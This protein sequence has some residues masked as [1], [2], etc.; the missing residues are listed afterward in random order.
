[1]TGM[2]RV[3]LVKAG[4]LT[5]ANPR[6]TFPLGIMSLASVLRKQ[7][8]KVMIADTRLGQ[9]PLAA[10]RSFSPQIVGISSLTVEAHSLHSIAQGMK[11]LRNPPLVVAGGPHPTSFSEEVLSDRC[12]DCVAL[13]E[14]EAIFPDLASRWEGGGFASVR[15]VAFRENGGIRTTEPRPPIDDLDSLP[16]PA[17]DLVDLPLYFRRR[18]MASIGLRPYMNLFTSRACPYRC[19]YCHDIFGKGF[20]ARSPESVV[21]EM[22]TLASQYG[23]RDYELLDDVFNLDAKRVHRV[24]DMILARG[25]RVKISFPNGLRTDRLDRDLLRKMKAAGVAHISVAVETASSR[26][27]RLI[28]KH[29]DLDKVR[30][31]ISECHRLGIFTRGFFMLGFP[32]ETEEE[33]MET[34]RFAVSSDLHTAL[35]FIVIP[36]KGTP[37]SEMTKGVQGPGNRDLTEYD[38]IDGTFNLSG[39]ADRTLFSAQKTAFRQFYLSPRR[40]VRLLRAYPAPLSH[41]LRYGAEA[42]AVWG[43]RG[44]R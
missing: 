24:M 33:M 26:L 37:L 7:G 12:I 23:I 2:A 43:W 17:W 36:F 40:I 16:F 21:S 3:L 5:R 22:E 27:Q 28:K 9:D 32:T 4:Y 8:H 30:E 13:G 41:L 14:G 20:R 10:A 31:M 6:V 38:Y 18:S 42:L 35:F 44:T 15:G 34:I 1:M 25:M 11:S 19:I 29:L 39:V